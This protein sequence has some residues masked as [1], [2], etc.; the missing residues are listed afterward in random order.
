MLPEQFARLLRLVNV[1]FMQWTHVT[2]RFAKDLVYLELQNKAD[3]IPVQ[4]KNMLKNC[5]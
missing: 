5:I 4:K 2:G 1:A 3:K